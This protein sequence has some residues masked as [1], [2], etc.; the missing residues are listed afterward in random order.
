[1]AYKLLLKNNTHVLIPHAVYTAKIYLGLSAFYIGQLCSAFP[2][3]SM[4]PLTTK[5]K[6]F[7]LER[8]WS[9]MNFLTALRKI[10]LFF[11]SSMYT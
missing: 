8:S 7:D 11:I 6:G 9:F 2:L 10:Q 1:M 4:N 5:T 3:S